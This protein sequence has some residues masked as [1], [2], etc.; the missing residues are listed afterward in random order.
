AEQ[1]GELAPY[2]AI[3]RRRDTAVSEHFE[4]LAVLSQDWL[5]SHP[6]GTYPRGARRAQLHDVWLQD[7]IEHSP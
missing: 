6:A 7:D 2:I 1:W 5:S 3:A 4:Y